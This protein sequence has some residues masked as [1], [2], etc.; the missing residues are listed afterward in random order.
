MTVI[1]SHFTEEESEAQT[2][3]QVTEQINEEAKTQ[4]WPPNASAQPFTEMFA[5]PPMVWRA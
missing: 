3:Q 2:G 5:A 1:L 4:T